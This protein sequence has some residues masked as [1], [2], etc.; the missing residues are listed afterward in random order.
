M[1]DELPH[2]FHVLLFYKDWDSPRTQSFDNQEEMAE[3]VGQKIGGFSDEYLAD[4]VVQVFYGREV[5]IKVVKPAAVVSVNGEKY[6]VEK[7]E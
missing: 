1:S 5:P 3:W 4:L 2:K 7:V 6:L